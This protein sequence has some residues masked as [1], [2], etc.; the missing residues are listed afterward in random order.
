[1]KYVQLVLTESQAVLT[2]Q[3]LA[4]SV[5]DNDDPIEREQ[6]QQLAD[7]FLSVGTNPLA[8]PV[9]SKAMARSIKKRVRRHNSALRP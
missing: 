7:F 3:A 9:K 2:A 4:N 1:M 5:I 6:L 8:F